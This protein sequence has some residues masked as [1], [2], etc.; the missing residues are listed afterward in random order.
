MLRET[1]YRNY[2]YDGLVDDWV[3]VEEEAYVLQ[4][5]DI[6]KFIKYL[7]FTNP[8]VCEW[9]F[10]DTNPRFIPGCKYM[11]YIDHI[12]TLNKG[13]GE[14]KVRNLDRLRHERKH[15]SPLDWNSFSMLRVD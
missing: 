1:T 11:V 2:F 12:F 10:I 9:K 4:D 6:I 8:C 5:E 15:S 14:V 3:Y 7:Q 13:W